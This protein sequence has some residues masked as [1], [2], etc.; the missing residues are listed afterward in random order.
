MQ[1][2]EEHLCEILV[3]IKQVKHFSKN[4]SL[5]PGDRRGGSAASGLMGSWIRIPPGT[6]MSDV[7]LYAVR[8]PCDRPIHR[9]EE[10][11]QVWCVIE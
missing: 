11:H 7:S 2:N 3:C 6:W 4:R 8:S 5:W 10:F 9:P 1:E